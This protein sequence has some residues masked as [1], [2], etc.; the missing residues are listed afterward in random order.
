MI[1]WIKAVATH[2]WQSF[3]PNLKAKN[4]SFRSLNLVLMFQRFW[5]TTAGLS[6]IICNQERVLSDTKKLLNVGSTFVRN[7]HK[8]PK[9]E[10]KRK[11][12]K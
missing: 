2:R 11:E 3:V 9:K 6:A 4:V 8:E 5:D 10:E 7:L 1:L 12:N